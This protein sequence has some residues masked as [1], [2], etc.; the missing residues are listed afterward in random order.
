MLNFMAINQNHIVEELNGVR[1]AIVEKN[2]TPERV[3]FLKQLLYYNHFTVV[4]VPSPAPKAAPAKP[5]AEGEVAPPASVL[6]ETYTVGVTNEMFNATNA[7]FGRL[8]HT[9]DGHIVTLAYWHQKERVSTDEVPY[10]ETN[11]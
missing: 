2:V 1:C 8:L 6:P 9:P 3:N 10:F 5:L 7:V 11:L 4:I